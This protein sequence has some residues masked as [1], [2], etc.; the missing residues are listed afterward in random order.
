MPGPTSR[1]AVPQSRFPY[2]AEAPAVQLS[3]RLLICFLWDDAT[4]VARSVHLLNGRD[5]DRMSI[6]QLRLVNV[7]NSN[8]VRISLFHLGPLQAFS[9]L[10]ASTAVGLVIGVDD[11][12]RFY[13]NLVNCDPYQDMLFADKAGRKNSNQILT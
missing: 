7:I 8:Y 12:A 4:K 10:T 1:K 13:D 3:A 2:A 9:K 6:R 5:G 11:V